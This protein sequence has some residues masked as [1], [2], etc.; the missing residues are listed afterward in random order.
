MKTYNYYGSEHSLF[1]KNHLYKGVE[2]IQDLYDAL[3]HSWSKE[4]CTSRLRHKWSETDYTC[5]Q[6][7]ITA[8]IVQDI[9]GG[10]IHEIPLETGGVH[11][12][13]LVDGKAVDLA[14]EQFG[15]R[16][17][18]LDYQGATI[19]NREF[20]MLEPEKKDRYE[21]LKSNLTTYLSNNQN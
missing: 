7:A 3:T 12:F 17:K 15:D 9:F 6:C 16:V 5:G 13:N 21:L 8:F 18:D 10:D 20:R 2:T 11:C 19:Q 1:V 4:T 14:S